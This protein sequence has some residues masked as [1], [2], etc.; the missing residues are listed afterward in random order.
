MIITATYIL[1]HVGPIIRRPPIGPRVAGD[2]ARVPK[3][4]LMQLLLPLAAALQWLQPAAAAATAAAALSSSSSSSSSRATTLLFWDLDP[5]D[6]KGLQNGAELTLNRPEKLGRVLKPEHPWESA[7]LGGYDQVLK[8]AEGDYRFY[9]LCNA[10]FTMRPQR[11]C[12]ARSVDGKSWTKPLL[13]VASFLNST[14][15][16]IVFPEYSDEYTEP[17][18]VFIDGNPACPPSERFKMLLTWEPSAARRG[19]ACLGGGGSYC[20][21]GAYTLVSADGL[22]WAPL[23]RPGGKLRAAYLGSDT[24]QTGHWDPV[25]AKYV[26][27][28]RGH[29][30]GPAERTVLRCVTSDLTD[31]TS[32]YN[33][34]VCPTVLAPDSLEHA[35]TDYYTS[36]ATPYGPV[37]DGL[38]VFFPT[39]YRHFEGSQAHCT[40]PAGAGNCGIVDIRFAFSR[41]RGAPGSVKWV[42]ATRGNGREAVIPLGECSCCDNECG[43]CRTDE[44]LQTTAFDTAEL[45]SVVGYLEDP[46]DGSLTFFY[47]GQPFSHGQNTDAARCNASADNPAGV[48]WALNHGIGAARYRKHGFT[49]IDAPANVFNCEANRSSLP[50]FT[51]KPIA[52]ALGCK[53]FRVLVNAQTSAAG[54]VF[55]SIE[56]FPGNQYTL[57][58]AQPIQG[59]SVQRVAMWPGS[60]AAAGPCGPGGTDRNGRDH[61]GPW[62]TQCSYEMPDRRCGGAMFPDVLRCNTTA[63]CHAIDDGTCYGQHSVCNGSGVCAGPHSNDSWWC[64]SKRLP[65]PPPLPGNEAIAGVV[66]VPPGVRNVTLTVALVAAKLFSLDVVCDTT[67]K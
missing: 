22:R 25:L 4:G 63:D 2:A 17:G 56:G 24:Q 60:G 34:T 57:A 52:L 10:D 19:Q 32:E 54:S 8:V 29:Q 18:T 51:T 66:P 38:V 37:A 30:P 40:C 12:L 36:G 53:S 46:D 26:V 14:Q 20:K 27:F 1:Q 35:G 11:V 13:G 67:M 15:N 45:Y 31:W 23:T 48:I 3:L 47:S 59:N 33:S 61:R 41:A 7:E 6:E 43:W 65:P 55:V 9:Y 64:V 21:P 5:L 16:N 39:P 28:V 58:A 44:Q 62:C 49:S 50:R 42:P